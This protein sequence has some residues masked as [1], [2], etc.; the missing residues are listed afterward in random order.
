MLTLLAAALAVAAPT[1]TPAHAV[2]LYADAIARS[3]PADL[4]QAFQPSAIMYC[5]DGQSISATYQSQWQAR[6]AGARPPSP[7]STSTEWIDADET[8]ALVRLRSV[9]GEKTYVDYL[10]LAH[11]TTG[12]RIVGKLCQADAPEETA[13]RS[14]VE[15]TIATKLAADRAWDDSLLGMSIDP[16]ALVMSVEG[17]EFVAASVPEW[18][19]R[20]RDRRRTSAGN[21][22]DVTS[23]VIDARAGI[24]VARWSFRSAA[25]E[26]IDR[27]LVMRTPRG[28]RIM[29]LLFVKEKP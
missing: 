21:S 4:S 25:G 22:F 16:R 17:G 9:R 13:S 14:A 8:S 18:Q 27:A 19:A 11:L 26:Y 20:Y 1:D 23:Q 6:L 10:L 5:T 3:S 2:A 24:G 7:V 29:A 15:A 12:W 28:W